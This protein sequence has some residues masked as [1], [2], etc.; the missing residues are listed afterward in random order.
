MKRDPAVELRILVLAIFLL[1]GAYVV[2]GGQGAQLDV[3]DPGKDEIALNAAP[4]WQARLAH[5]S[6]VGVW[7]VGAV[8]AFELNGAPEVFA[9]DDKGRCRILSC[10]SGR[11]TSFET[12]YDHEWLGAFAVA[13]LDPSRGG[14][15][16]YTGGKRGNLF[17]VIAHRDGGFDTS[18][19]LR[20]PAEELHT[21]IAGDLLRSRPGDELLVFTH[22]GNV[23]DVRREAGAETGFVGPRHAR[24]DG[25]VRQAILLPQGSEDRSD[26]FIACVTRNGEVMLLRMRE[27]DFER[28]VILKEPMGFGRIAS[29]PQTPGAPLVLYVIR[30]DGLVLRLAGK[31]GGEFQR[32]AIYAG[33]Q[34][35]RGIAAGRFDADPDVETVAVFGYS[36]KVEL[37]SRRGDE[38]PFEAKTIF[39]DVDRGHWLSTIEIDGRNS[40]D[41]L[42]GSGYSGRVFQLAR[43]PGHGMGGIPAEKREAVKKD[44]EKTASAWNAAPRIAIASSAQSV[45]DLVPLG[46]RGGFETKTLLFETLVRLGDDGRIVPG[47]AT[48]WRIEDGGKRFVFTLREGARFHDGTVVDAEAVRLHFARWVGLPEHAWIVASE[49]IVDV[50]AASARELVITLSEPTALLPDLCVVNP[51]AISAPSCFDREGRLVAAIGS[52]PYR[53]VELVGSELRLERFQSARGLPEKLV[54]A[55]VAPRGGD[56]SG[57]IAEGLAAGSIDGAADGAYDVLPRGEPPPSEALRR[58]DVAGSTLFYLSFRDGGPAGVALRRAVAGAIDREALAALTCVA[59]A[60]S[61]RTL[62]GGSSQLGKDEPFATSESPLRLVALAADPFAPLAHAIA[63]QLTAAG[64]AT[65]CDALEPSA[66]AAALEAGHYDLRIERTWGA[67]YDPYLTL[68][69]RL[70]PSRGRPHAATHRASGIDAAWVEG[71]LALTRVADPAA[72]CVALRE[73]LAALDRDAVFVPLLAPRR[74]VV[75]RPGVLE[76]ELS[77]DA[78]RFLPRAP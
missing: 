19:V 16:M 59:P 37:L 18:L 33:P 78:Y 73:F 20:Y 58:R 5:R 61:V 1:L 72:F 50:K 64:I 63:K 52:G 46:Y 51:C 56:V 11:W 42:I 38:G 44:D 29:K 74:L 23:Y 25:R 76:L 6:D 4:G 24:L 41:E 43:D 36:K 17:R 65:R 3:G 47:L 32:E 35:P 71:A 21:A 10:Y 49:R 67:P 28:Q 9:L 70:V 75:D 66:H 7:T 55:L 15:E 54:V 77:R 53:L 27:Q 69:N 34:G 48:A 30:D 60:D 31:P 22:L 13:D 2:A 68:V 14:V 62:A 45:A 8:K 57:A 39:E 12:V 40:T 26:P